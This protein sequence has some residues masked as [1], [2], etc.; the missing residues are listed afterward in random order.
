MLAECVGCAKS[1]E[2]VTNTPFLYRGEFDLVQAEALRYFFLS[3][4]V[5]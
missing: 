2:V 1:D 4:P 3:P 5:A